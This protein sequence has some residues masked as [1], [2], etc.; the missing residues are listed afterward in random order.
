M[1]QEDIHHAAGVLDI[2]AFE[3]KLLNEAKYHHCLLDGTFI[4]ETLKW[5]FLMETLEWKLL[6]EAKPLSL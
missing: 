6:N 3:W 1:S 2:N 4:I 5:N